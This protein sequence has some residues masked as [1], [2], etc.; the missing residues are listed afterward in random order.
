[1]NRAVVCVVIVAGVF[2][3]GIPAQEAHHSFAATYS[4]DKTLTIEGKLL[5]FDFRNPHSFVTY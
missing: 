5:D 3:G 2:A 1:M 4:E